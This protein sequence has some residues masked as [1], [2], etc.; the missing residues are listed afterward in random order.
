[1]KTHFN[2][3]FPL[4]VFVLF[5]ATAGLPQQAYAQRFSHSNFGGGGASRGNVS[6]PAPAMSR[7]APAPSRPAPSVNRSAPAANRTPAPV[8]NR[9]VEPEVNNRTIN[10]GSRNFGNHDL[11]RNNNVAAPP[12]NARD[13]VTS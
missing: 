3:I 5:M 2:I 1:M 6:H 8:M 4:T 12:V 11:S 13:R 10:G 7:P 9:T